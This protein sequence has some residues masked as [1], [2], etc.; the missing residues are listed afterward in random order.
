VPSHQ[1]DIEPEA[2]IILALA[3]FANG[4]QKTRMAKNYCGRVV[5]SDEKP[6]RSRL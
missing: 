5:T 3:I 4:D 1:Q 2:E 6:L